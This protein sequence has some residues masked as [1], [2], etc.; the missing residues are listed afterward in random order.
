MTAAVTILKPVTIA[1]AQSL[2]SGSIATTS[3][4]VAGTIVIPASYPTLT[5]PVPTYSGTKAAAISGKTTKPANARIDITGVANTS[6]TVKV[7]GWTQVSGGA[8]APTV[9]A[10]TFYSPSYGTKTSNIVLLDTR[11]KA[12]LYVGATLTIPASAASHIFTFGPVFSVNY[13]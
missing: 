4:T 11:G 6:V 10:T 5:T 3:T 1:T 12:S 2:N 9:S 13:N 8:P 7:T